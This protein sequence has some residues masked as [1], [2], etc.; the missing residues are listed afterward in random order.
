MDFSGDIDSPYYPLASPSGD[1][2]QNLLQR[3][4][5]VPGMSFPA[6]GGWELGRATGAH[7]FSLRAACPTRTPKPGNRRRVAPVQSVFGSK[8]SCSP[9]IGV[10]NGYRLAVTRISGADLVCS[11]RVSAVLLERAGFNGAA[12]DLSRKYERTTQYAVRHGL[13]QWGRD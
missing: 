11:C 13:L 6:A 7:R 4:D 5:E 8:R 9:P 2:R 3:A 12:T 1:S 10:G